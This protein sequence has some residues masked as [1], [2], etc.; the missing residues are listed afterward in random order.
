MI[1]SQLAAHAVPPHPGLDVDSWTT[2]AAAMPALLYLVLRPVDLILGLPSWLGAVMARQAIL[3][4]VRAGAASATGMDMLGAA[5]EEA[6]TCEPP[7]GVTVEQ[8]PSEIETEIETDLAN[9]GAIDLATLRES[10]DPKRRATLLSAIDSAFRDVGLLHAQYYRD[11]RV[12]DFTARCVAG[13]Q[14]AWIVDA[15]SLADPMPDEDDTET[16]PG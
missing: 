15:S 1:R 7:D 6:R 2:I 16:G 11:P 13:K 3:S 9:Q 5:F 14:R 8:V 12:I 10:I 4:G